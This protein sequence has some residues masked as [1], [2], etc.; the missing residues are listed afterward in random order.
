MVKSITNLVFVKNCYLKIVCSMLR[1][2]VHHLDS[3]WL[4]DPYPFSKF[5]SNSVVKL[6]LFLKGVT[7]KA[8]CT[9]LRFHK[10]YLI[11]L[12]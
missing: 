10:T 4:F 8:R 2:T 6:E 11:H 7:F 3:K 12:P 9:N 1:N 5:S